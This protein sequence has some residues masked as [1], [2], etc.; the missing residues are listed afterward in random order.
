MKYQ[1]SLLDSKLM[2]REDLYFEN[3]NKSTQYSGGPS[4]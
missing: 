1:N 4:K 2:N 3:N